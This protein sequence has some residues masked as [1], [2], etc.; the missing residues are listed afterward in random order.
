MEAVATIPKSSE[1]QHP[2]KPRIRASSRLEISSPAARGTERC[3]NPASQAAQRESEGRSSEHQRI[4]LG[5][6]GI[7]YHNNYN[8]E[9]PKPYSD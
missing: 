4:L 9:P 8:K 7:L 1:Y 6:G 3:P 5:F 2:K